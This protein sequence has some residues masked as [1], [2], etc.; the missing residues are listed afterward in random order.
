M[1]AAT[2]GDALRHVNRSVEALAPINDQGIALAGH[3]R[4]EAASCW[5]G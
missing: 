1:S 4:L 3:L 5:W 2:R